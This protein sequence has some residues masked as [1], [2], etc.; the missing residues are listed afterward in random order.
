M[1]IRRLILIAVAFTL[2]LSHHHLFA[3]TSADLPRVGMISV[4]SAASLSVVVDAFVKGLADQGFVEGKNIIIDRRYANGQVDQ[5]PILGAELAALKSAVI[6]APTPQAAAAAKKVTDTIPIVF[7]VAQEPVKNGFVNS[8][9]RPGGN[10]TGITDISADLIPKRLELLSASVKKL[11]RLTALYNSTY[12]GT[13]LQLLELERVAKQRKIA[14]S[15]V[16]V[17]SAKDFEKAFGQVASTKPDALFVIESPVFYVNRKQIADF[18][19]NQRYPSIFNTGESVEAGGFMSY[20]AGY[21]DLYKQASI[22]VAKILRGAKAAD[23]P[24]EQPTR[25]ELV[26]NQKTAKALGLTF[27]PSVLLMVDRQID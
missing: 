5:L 11:T 23:L 20:G 13:A 16:D 15:Q 26:V 19:L 22:H 18:A 1:K 14:L 6:F 10:M 21:P 12:P 24:V 25:F 7:A 9:A 8:L 27:P 17:S 4:G 3:Q 2:G